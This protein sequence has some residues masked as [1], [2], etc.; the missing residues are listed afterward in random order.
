M[1]QPSIEASQVGRWA[2]G[3]ANASAQHPLASWMHEEEDEETERGRIKQLQKDERGVRRT[4]KTAT[5]KATRGG[6][7]RGFW[8]RAKDKEET[9][10]DKPGKLRRV[11]AR[12]PIGYRVVAE[13]ARRRGGAVQVAPHKDGP[14][15]RKRAALGTVPLLKSY[16]GCMSMGAGRCISTNEVAFAC[17][18]S[19]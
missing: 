13:H 1:E 11:R 2:H 8:Q 16:V 5:R 4:K 14:A 12:P 6:K 19:G 3:A 17:T 18:H 9:D 10:N 15:D 7:E